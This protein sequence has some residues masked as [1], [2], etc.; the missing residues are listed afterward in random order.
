[1]A[2][3]F[4]FPI[5]G[6]VYYLVAIYGMLIFSFQP[7]NITFLWL[8]FALSVIFIHHFGIRILPFIFMGSFFANLN[9]MENGDLSLSIIHTSISA[10]ADTI[11]PYISSF[12]LKKYVDDKFD[13]IKGFLPFIMYGVL[14][15]TFISSVIISI[16]LFFGKYITF[17]KIFSYI[18]LLIFTDG[19]GLILIYPIYKYFSKAAI[20]FNEIKIVS[21]FSIIIFSTTYL[22]FSYH[23]LI[24]LLP[25][26]MLLF[27]FKIRGDIVA[28]VLLFVVIEL[29]ALSARNENIFYG[30]NSEESLL[31][32]MSYISNLVIVVIGITQHQ[33]NLL[34]H[35]LSSLTDALTQTKNRLAY[36][37]AIENEISYFNQTKIPFSILLFDIDNFK[38]I[39][40]T[41]NHRIGDLVL[42]ELSSLI[43]KNIRNSDS[44][45]RIGGEEFIILFPNTTSEITVEVAEKLRIIVEKGLNTINDKTIT[46]S[47]GVTQIKENDTEDSLYRRV[48]KLLYDSKRTGKNKVTS[49]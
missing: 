34:K 10:L 41:Y 14:I 40:D 47:I 27:A 39:N 43:Q 1:L 28:F 7:S 29:I 24:F 44:L 36:E 25:A 21:L 11:A 35:Q 46:I 37:E 22:S 38:L 23:F 17:D 6:F 19:L 48:D 9:G 32:L 33:R 20:T 3:L 31:M 30:K 4:I 45:F 42:I 13:S 18:L 5:L 12:L 2:R 16:N 26:I 8:P 15:P 49:Y